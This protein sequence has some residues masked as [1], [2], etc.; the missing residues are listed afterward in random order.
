MDVVVC[1]RCYEILDYQRN[2]F[3]ESNTLSESKLCN[4]SRESIRLFLRI[5]GF[6]DFLLCPLFLEVE[7]RGFENWICFRPQVKGGEDSYSVG[8]L[9]K[10]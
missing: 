9:R 8:P 4:T 10:S 3:L 6:L 5:T 1:L 7:I 2:N